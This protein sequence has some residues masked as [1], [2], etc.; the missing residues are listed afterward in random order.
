MRQNE[1]PPWK[2][3]ERHPLSAEYPDITGRVREECI[4]S[5][6]RYGIINDRPIVIHEGK[7]IDGWQLLQWCKEADIAPHIVPLVLKNGLTVEKWVELTNDHRR[8]EPYSRVLRRVEERRKRVVH[9]RDEGKSTREIAEL[10]NVSQ[11]TVLHDLESGEHPQSPEN[12]EI[13][14]GVPKTSVKGKDGRTYP[15]SKTVKCNRCSRL[16][17]PVK[18]CDGCKRAT[19]E[20]A[21]KKK[22][23]AAAKKAETA[24]KKAAREAESKRKADEAEAEKKEAARLK[25]EA[26]KAKEQAA[27]DKKAAAEKEKADR[28]GEK[29][30]ERIKKEEEKRKANESKLVDEL[31]IPIQ[32]H[33]KEAFADVPKFDELIK[34]LRHAK[35]LYSELASS[36]GGAYLLRP[37]ISVNARDSWKHN[38][39]E[40][41]IMNI[42]DCVPSLTACP[43][44]IH[45]YQ[46]HDNECVLCHG[47]NWTRPI[48]KNEGARAF[49]GKLKESF[50]IMEEVASV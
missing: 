22:D 28:A 3:L 25:D 4:E 16:N 27:A 37:G 15:K 35:K 41:A 12:G 11:T 33:A 23:D 45:E 9:L 2:D 7:I 46:N 26:R 48:G 18:G 32:E 19:A 38:G 13:S 21:K 5:L 39:I 10:E 29:E 8:H 17:E 24:A 47:L 40:T 6:K 44:S 20:A 14:N 34:V 49:F 1:N 36:A 31:G 43:Y 42:K 50:G 30:A